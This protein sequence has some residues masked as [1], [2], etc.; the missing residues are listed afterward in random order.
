MNA[1]TSNPILFQIKVDT[2][3]TNYDF[4]EMKN[5]FKTDFHSYFSVVYTIALQ[6]KNHAQL[7]FRSQTNET[8]HDFFKWC[9]TTICV[10]L[11]L[12]IVSII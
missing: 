12:S 5:T 10:Q 7:Y 4:V 8:E 2:N 11:T 1:R 6:F 3:S 9:V